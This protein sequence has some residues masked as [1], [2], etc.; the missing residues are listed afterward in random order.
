MHIFSCSYSI[1]IWF[2][3]RSHPPV[4]EEFSLVASNLTMWLKTMK[5][6]VLFFQVLWICVFLRN[7]QIITTSGIE[8]FCHK[9]AMVEEL[10]WRGHIGFD[11]FCKLFLKVILLISAKIY[12]MFP[13]LD[14]CLAIQCSQKKMRKGHVAD[15]KNIL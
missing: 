6:I 12:K 13:L 9:W 4:S 15:C 7:N 5:Q 2:F 10:H 3:V 14:V 11:F 8:V 1:W